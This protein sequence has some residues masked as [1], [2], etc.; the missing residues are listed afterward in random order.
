MYRIAIVD[1]DK[2]FL[3][4]TQEIIEKTFTKAKLTT[5]I[6]TFSNPLQLDHNEDFDVL[7]LDIDM[8]SINGIEL[9]KQYLQNNN[10]TLIIFITNKY[11]LV[12]NAFSVHPFDFIKKE[13]FENSLIKSVNQLINKLDRDNKIISIETKSG[14]TKINCKKILYCES[15]GHT[16]Y[17]HTTTRTIETNKYKLSNLESIINNN[18]FYMIN[19]SYLVHWKYII[20]IENKNAYLEDGTILPISKRRF[21]DSLSSYKNYTL[22]NI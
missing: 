17:I 14:I 15:Y 12:F 7:F 4:L 5:I 10:D 16:C 13:N 22:R 2:K 20:N 6:K 9:A 8:P 21:K 11:D 18:D 19:Q 3:Q 1:D